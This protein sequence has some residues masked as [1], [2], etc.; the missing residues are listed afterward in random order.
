MTFKPTSYRFSKRAHPCCVLQDMINY[1]L[2]EVDD[3]DVIL[4]HCYFN[5]KMFY[6][7][8]KNK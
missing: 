7:I 3:F 1:A 8:M 4:F 5:I 2:T 6:R